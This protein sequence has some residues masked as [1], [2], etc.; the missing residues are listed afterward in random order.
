[1]QDWGQKKLFFFFNK[2]DVHGA[3]KKFGKDELSSSKCFALSVETTEELLKIG[4]NHYHYENYFPRSR[5]DE[6]NEI[7]KRWAKEFCSKIGTLKVKEINILPLCDL[8]LYNYF[9]KKLFQYYSIK[10]M[11]IREKPQKIY[12]GSE[13]VSLKGIFATNFDMLSPVIKFVAKR[14]K[15][16]IDMIKNSFNDKLF[17]IQILKIF[18]FFFKFPG[19]NFNNYK[20][21]KFNY[22]LIGHH[23]HL[24][25][26][27]NVIKTMKNHSLVIGRIGAAEE[28][29]KKNMIDYFSPSESL[30]IRLYFFFLIK[31]FIFLNKLLSANKTRLSQI[32]EINGLSLFGLFKLKLYSLILTDCSN[33][34]V[35]ILKASET[36]SAFSPNLIVN[37][38]EDTFIRSYLAVAKK[39]KIP[40]LEIE[41]GITTGYDAEF[42]IAN[43]LAVWG[44]IPKKIYA[45][46]GFDRK[47]IVI[48]GW[49][50]FEDYKKIGFRNN[51]KIDPN[52]FVITFLAQ[53]PE[54]AS[55]L[56]MNKTPFENLEIFFKAVSSFGKKAKVIVRLHP[57]ADRQLPSII[58]K[59][60]KVDF[61]L[62]EDET[63]DKSLEQ[64]DIVIGQTTSA[65]LDAIIMHKS[66]IY[67]PSMRWPAKFA[68]GSGA[69][70]EAKDADDI[71]RFVNLIIKKGMSRQML[72]AQKRFVENY[73][74]FSKNSLV[75][76]T[77][78]IRSMTKQ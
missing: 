56:F 58:A 10:Q 41:H 20:F 78:V 14:E 53:D 34:T 57:R 28:E 71:V 8:T 27:L 75:E 18:T 1:M 45:S 63:L 29:L 59:K 25:N 35:T 36:L 6:L 26:I 3:Q 76:I 54:G 69:F 42:T 55:L 16:N 38:T 9:A 49:P 73:C 2:G 12:L 19:I 33:L 72:E 15:L 22:L 51:H 31:K 67:L 66:V 50:A 13:Q 62:S 74:N 17:E 21:K 39:L 46:S 23:Y 40:T 4:I 44:Q 37:L 65:T 11:F 70:Y 64:S 43:K 30:N 24:K 68:E 60:Y 32:F 61:I 52:N 48:T 5:A 77:K 7:A 47:K